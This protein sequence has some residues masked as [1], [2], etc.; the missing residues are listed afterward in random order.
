M[1]TVEPV[2]FLYLSF[3]TS[4]ESLQIEYFYEVPGQQ[5]IE[6]N[7]HD[8]VNPVKSANNDLFIILLRILSSEHF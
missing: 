3:V 4:E 5:S 1:N 8:Q 6:Q 7:L 2:T